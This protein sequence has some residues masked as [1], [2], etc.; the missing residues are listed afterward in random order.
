MLPEAHQ[1]EKALAHTVDAFGGL[2][3][4]IRNMDASSS[5][6]HGE[7]KKAPDRGAGRG[8]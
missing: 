7:N 6:D 2:H 4:F 5:T 8:G 1:V 3:V